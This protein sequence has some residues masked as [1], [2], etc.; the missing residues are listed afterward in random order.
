MKKRV[1]L[2]HRGYPLG[3]NAGDKVRTLNMAVS[4]Q[5]MGN[6]VVLLAFFTKGFSLL[7]QEKR[8]V[9]QGIRSVFI[10][11]LPNR[12]GLG[13]FAAFIRSIC[14]KL[15]CSF[16]SIELIQAELASSATAARFVSRIPLITDFHSDIV[17]E[18]EMDSYPKKVVEHAVWENR[19]ALQ[20][21]HAIIA[22][23]H[24]LIK[25]LQ[26][27]GA[28]PDRSYVLP[29]NFDTSHF[30]QAAFSNREKLREELGLTNRIVLC[31][32]G[33]LH[34]WQCVK[35]TL[36][37]I[38]ALR[39]LNPAFYL[40]LFTNDDI[41]PFS[42]LLKKLEGNCLIKGLQKN[43]VPLFLSIID[44]GFVLR[45]N[46]LVNLNAS[47]TK[48]SEYLA[49][50]AA[51]VTTRYAGDVPLQVQ[52]SGCGIVL[53]EPSVNREKLLAV[54]DYLCYYHQYYGQFSQKAQAYVYS[55]RTWAFNEEKLALLYN[56]LEL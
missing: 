30:Q 39:E 27:Y 47:P 31:Y 41:T 51:I 12:F 24:N 53:D 40:C 48:G 10:Y 20:H 5:K 54:H 11:S 32:L 33:G 28:I 29:C 8:N 18:L 26:V 3:G 13:K 45:S 38:I 15:I 1:L 6:E 52:T 2:I 23:S 46:S 49:S 21:S 35:E 56:R 19:F 37:L 22:V 43:E 42:A 25:N 44:A 50:G 9:P 55:N 17:P 4:L 14:T 7:S 34:T 36:E 16:Y